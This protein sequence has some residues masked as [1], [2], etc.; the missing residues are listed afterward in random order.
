MQSTRDQLRSSKVRFALLGAIVTSACGGYS[1]TTRLVDGELMHGSPVAPQAYAAYFDGKLKE[2]S[3][4][5]QAARESYL[6][7]TEFEDGD[8]EIWTSIGRLSCKL[9]IAS[10]DEEFAQALELDNRYAPTW[11]EKA[12]CELHRRNPRRALEFARM[13][14]IAAPYDVEPTKLLANL[15]EQTQEVEAAVQQWVGY[16][17]KH[18][19]SR[20][21]WRALWLLSHK[22]HVTPWESFAESTLQATPVHTLPRPLHETHHRGAHKPLLDAILRADLAAARAYA[23]DHGLPQSVIL[24]L[25]CDYGQAAIALTHAKLLV[26][27]YPQSGDIRVLGLLAANRADD[28]ETFD[29]WLELPTR[30]TNL[31][32]VGR[33]ALDQLLRERAGLTEDELP[34]ASE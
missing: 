15:Y 3:G 23:T 14:Q 28:H 11:L 16:V 27:A 22:H 21:G 30:L 20:L 13:A 34:T 31:T 18:P 12:G 32:A 4:E 25:A 5:T 6:T 29:S 19:E 1:S 2:A 9:D 24:E 8:P 17:A 7:A 10:A 33:R 26:P